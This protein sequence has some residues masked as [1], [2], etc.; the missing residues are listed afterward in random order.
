LLHVWGLEALRY[1]DFVRP[2]S[3][4]VPW[5]ATL[6]QHPTGQ[7]ETLADRFVVSSPQEGSSEKTVVM[8]LRL[9]PPI[10]CPAPNFLSFFRCQPTRESSAWRGS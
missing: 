3:V 10:L 8:A 4:V 9:L 7:F 5:V 1:A 2:S 6:S